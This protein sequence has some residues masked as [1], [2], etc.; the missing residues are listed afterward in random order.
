MSYRI[1]F[2]DAT[3][4]QQETISKIK[5]LALSV[6]GPYTLDGTKQRYLTIRN[7]YALRDNRFKISPNGTIK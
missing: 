6:T 3:I 5:R 1:K 4:A 7:S 2:V